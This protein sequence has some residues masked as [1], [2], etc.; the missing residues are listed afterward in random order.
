MLMN[1]AFTYGKRQRLGLRKSWRKNLEGRELG[2]LRVRAVWRVMA[3][4]GRRMS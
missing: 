3:W 1:G 2:Q 4:K